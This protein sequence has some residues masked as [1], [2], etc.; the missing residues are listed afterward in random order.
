M[1]N[2]ITLSNKDCTDRV[3]GYFGKG[4]ME[5]DYSEAN[6]TILMDDH[7]TKLIYAGNEAGLLMNSWAVESGIYFL[8]QCLSY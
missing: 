5:Y 3:R 8:M 4:I 6:L 7:C 1:F 2:F